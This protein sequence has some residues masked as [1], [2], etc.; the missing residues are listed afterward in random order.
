MGDAGA[1]TTDDDE[2]AD[3]CARLREHG[4]RQRSTS[5]SARATRRGSTRSRRSSSCTSCRSS[6]AGTQQ[7]RAR[8]RALPRARSPASATSCC[9][10]SRPGSEPGLAPLRRPDA[11]RRTRSRAFLGERGIGTGR[12][13]PEPVHL[14]AA[15][16]RA[17]LRARRV[18]GRRGA[19]RASASRCRSS[20]ESTEEQLAHVV[21]AV[22][23]YFDGG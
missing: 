23:E 11:R 15:R 1:L 22:E 16:T 20:R 5:T 3:A 21:A 17:R 13:Y 10:R 9:R 19:R 8:R 6:T 12:H 7:R 14:C 4:Q 18:P 2:L